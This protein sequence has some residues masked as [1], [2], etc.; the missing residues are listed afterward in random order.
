MEQEKK[1]KNNT[2]SFRYFYKGDTVLESCV[3]CNSI[4]INTYTSE[5]LRMEG[6]NRK[7]CKNCKHNWFVNTF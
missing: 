6:M 1:Q 3:K 7:E 2:Q 4:N 5:F